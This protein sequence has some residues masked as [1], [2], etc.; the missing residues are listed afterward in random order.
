MKPDLKCD[1]RGSYPA[2]PDVKKSDDLIL[3]L[4]VLIV[5]LTRLKRLA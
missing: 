2:E 5:E 1:G 3:S 4:D